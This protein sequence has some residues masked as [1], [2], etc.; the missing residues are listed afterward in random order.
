MQFSI[1]EI[2]EIQKRIGDH[3]D[4]YINSLPPG[5]VSKEQYIKANMATVL[6]NILDRRTWVNGELS[7]F[8]PTN[9]KG[10]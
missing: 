2:Q 3:Y 7:V 10:G 5:M 8:D 4:K 1:S 6:K 9:N